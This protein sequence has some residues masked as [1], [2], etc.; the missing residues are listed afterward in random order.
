MAHPPVQHLHKL[1]DDL[2]C[3]ELVVRGVHPADEVQA[4]VPLVHQ[5]HVLP[6]KEVAQLEWPGK[7]QRG[8][9]LGDLRP[10][11]LG[12]GV[13]PLSQADLRLSAQQARVLMSHEQDCRKSMGQ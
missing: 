8:D 5:L 12:V 1:M 9:L 6:V 2:K 4:G 13:V 3:D 11:L 7:D 10:L